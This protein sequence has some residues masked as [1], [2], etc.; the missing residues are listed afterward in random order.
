MNSFGQ[1]FAEIGVKAQPGVTIFINSD[2]TL[3]IDG[4]ATAT[5][6]LLT[7]DRA[8][9]GGQYNDPSQ[10]LAAMGRQFVGKTGKGTP[11]KYGVFADIAY[12]P[13]NSNVCR[14]ITVPVIDMLPDESQIGRTTVV[15]LS[16]G[17]FK[18]LTG[19]DPRTKGN[20]TT[21]PVKIT[22]PAS[23]PPTLP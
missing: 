7:S 11:F 16:P 14:H 17:A 21:I 2:H 6:Y 22:L 3:V 9:N 13:P 5:Y 19:F 15:D 4:K 12:A 10:V 1:N 20:P 18:E 23:T 8:P